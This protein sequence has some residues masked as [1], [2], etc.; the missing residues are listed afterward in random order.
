MNGFT[1]PTGA[2]QQQTP[3]APNRNIN[4]GLNRESGYGLGD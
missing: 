2:N 1:G 3:Q 4:H